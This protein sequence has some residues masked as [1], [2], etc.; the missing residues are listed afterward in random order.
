MPKARIPIESPTFESAVTELEAIVA[1]MEGGDLPLAESLAQYR[2]GAEL[3]RFCR[4][5]LAD[6]EQ[7]VRILDADALKPHAD[8]ADAE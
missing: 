3:L 2:R 6:A 8:G 7:Q 4:A 5:Q 1:R